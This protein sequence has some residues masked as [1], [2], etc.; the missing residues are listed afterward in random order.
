MWETLNEEFVLPVYWEDKT[1][2]FLFNVDSHTG[3]GNIDPLLQ[4]L[5]KSRS[6]EI[7]A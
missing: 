3:K 4:D 5:V 1:V 6:R 7:W 2:S